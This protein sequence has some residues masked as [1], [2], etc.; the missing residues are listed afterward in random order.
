M[1]SLLD[2]W[3]DERGGFSLQAS[4]FSGAVAGMG[5]QRCGRFRVWIISHLDAAWCQRSRPADGLVRDG[6]S[7]GH[8]AGGRWECASQGCTHQP[9]CDERSPDV[10]PLAVGERGNCIVSDTRWRVCDGGVGPLPE[11]RAGS[12]GDGI[13]NVRRSMTGHIP[14]PRPIDPSFTAVCGSPAGEALESI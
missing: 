9:N 10:W 1:S 4:G 6:L 2:C 5:C 3:A 13:C 8:A 11:E 14:R 12:T 7:N